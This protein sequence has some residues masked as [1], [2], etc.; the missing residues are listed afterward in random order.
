MLEER[1]NYL[2]IAL[3]NLINLFNP[4]VILLGGIFA[5]GSDLLIPTLKKTIQ[6]TAFGGMGKNVQVEPTSFGWKAGVAGASALALLHFFYQ[7][8]DDCISW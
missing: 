3:A 4:Q 6:E 2:G 1:V 5:S 7:Q 8:N